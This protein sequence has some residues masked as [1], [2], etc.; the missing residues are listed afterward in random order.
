MKEITYKSHSHKVPED[1]A[2]DINKCFN[3][4]DSYFTMEKGIDY[5]FDSYSHFSIHEEML[6]DKVKYFSFLTQFL[7]TQSYFLV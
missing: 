6:K 5:Y 1:P 2:F 7:T 4:E 3:E